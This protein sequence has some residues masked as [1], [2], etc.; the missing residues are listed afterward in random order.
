MKF[1]FMETSSN[2]GNMLSMAAAAAFLPFLP[3]LP[4]QLLLNSFLYDAA[5]LPIPTDRV[6]PAFVRKPRRWDVRLIRRFMLVVGP[7][8]SLFDLLTFVVLLH[9]FHADAALFRTG[10]FVESL[11]TQVLV[12]FVIRTSARPWESRP[13]R[14][15]T[16]A[17]VAVAGLAFALPYTAVSE[18]LG[19]VPLPPAY[20]LFVAS[21][22]AAYLAA[23]EWA[24]RIVFER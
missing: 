3:M 11:A 10:W 24:K 15:L 9:L 5:Q 13:S 7:V 20:L 22:T 14:G 12:L 6:D 18:P 17:T 1:L 23:V 2:F 4:K 16:A 8:S 19:F 21:A